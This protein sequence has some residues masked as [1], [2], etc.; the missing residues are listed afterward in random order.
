MK[1]LGAPGALHP[2][3]P[4]ATDTWVYGAD[5]AHMTVSQPRAAVDQ[6]QARR[7]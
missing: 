1:T 7:W 5:R 6:R 3:L 2:S 4:S